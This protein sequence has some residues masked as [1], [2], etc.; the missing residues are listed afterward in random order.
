MNDRL[1]IL[2]TRNVKKGREM[3]EILVPKWDSQRHLSH[4]QIETL[5]AY[6][7]LA[8][9]VEDA[10]TFLGNA[11]KKASEAAIALKSW[12]I[13]DDSGLSVDHLDGAPGVF[14]ARYAG[15][16]GDDDANNRKLLA[17]LA[18]VPD[19]RRG[20]AFVCALAV[21]D[22]AGSIVLEAEGRCRG[23]ITHEAQGPAGFGYDPLFLIR[24]YH[25]TFGEL[26]PTVKHQLSHRAK[27]F[28]ILKPQLERLLANHK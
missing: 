13:A 1:L 2:A 26:G 5:A 4:L 28:G 21:A 22:P 19:V 23:R 24:E 27:A 18:G 20:A 9:T 7:D 15:Q 10:T 6:P 8:E 25:K 16:H 11:R 17:A 3:G 14:S 12:V